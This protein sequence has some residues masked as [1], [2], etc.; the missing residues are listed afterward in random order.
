M[1]TPELLIRE[2]SSGR[3]VYEIEGRKYPSVT[4]ILSEAYP[5]PE[6]MGWGAKMAAQAAIEGRHEGMS[7]REGVNFLQRAPYRYRRLRADNGT[8]VHEQLEKIL[9]PVAD[10]SRPVW[11]TDVR[12]DGYIMAARAFC[13]ANLLGV[14]ATECRVFSDRFGYAGTVDL[15]A[16]SKSGKVVMVDWKT[17]KS[18]Y[19][20]NA[21]QLAAYAAA[22]WMIDGKGIVRK[23]SPPGAAAVVRLEESG[24]YEAGFLSRANLIRYHD[25]FLQ[26]MDLKKFLDSA[27]ETWNKREKGERAAE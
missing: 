24:K 6:L 1:E 13:E 5:K 9:A 7:E 16:R 21:L 8:R 19:P 20:D 14:L 26:V 3:R 11:W 12:N 25:V 17:S 4:T 27:N 22:D 15:M 23:V 2:D 10:G 18:I